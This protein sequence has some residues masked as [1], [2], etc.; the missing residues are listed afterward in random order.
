[1][2]KSVSI[3]LAV[4]FIVLL[5]A[6]ALLARGCYLR[7]RQIDDLGRR[8]AEL[9]A[10]ITSLEGQIADRPSMPPGPNWENVKFPGVDNPGEW[11]AENLMERTDIIPWK[12]IMG[13]TM[14]IYDS[15]QIWFI[16]P[17]WCLAWA[18]DG[19]IGG[20][21]LLGYETEGRTVR[22]KLLDSASP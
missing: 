4:V 20:Y 10:R 6:A 7:N 8:N 2:K 13:G 15:S 18:E 12:G 22:W 1:M 17:G 3:Y 19:H 9:Q 16:G 11:L 5:A 21:M 14:R